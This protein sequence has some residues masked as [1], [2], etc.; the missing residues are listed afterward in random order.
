MNAH[1]SA[2]TFSE[3]QAAALAVRIREKPAATTG[4]TD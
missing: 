1:D 4:D 3:H 2:V